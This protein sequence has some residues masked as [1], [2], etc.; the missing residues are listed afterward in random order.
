MFPNT[1]NIGSEYWYGFS[2]FIPDNW[3]TDSSGEILA[4]WHNTPDAGEAGGSPPLAL[5]VSGATWF[6]SNKWD[7]ERVAK[8]SGYDGSVAYSV[9]TVGKGEWTDWVFHI[10]WSYQGKDGLLEVWKN[11]KRVV[12]KHGPNTFNDAKG[13]YFKFG[14][15][16]WDW[17]NPSGG[18]GNSKVSKR[19]VY[20]D[21]VRVGDHGA[22]YGD[23]AP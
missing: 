7:S 12:Q 5:S 13:P 3:A 18:R 14:I 22:S 16:K 4:Q 8:K 21:T 19:V 11:G 2:I 17:R 6:I 10:K 9:G 15:Y 20:H 1:F 23:V